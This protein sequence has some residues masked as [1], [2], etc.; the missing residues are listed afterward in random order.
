MNKLDEHVQIGFRA[1]KALVKRLDKLAGQMS[2]PGREVSRS[3]ALR[4][5]AFKGLEQLEAETSIIKQGKK[6]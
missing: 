6:R 2:E 4:L 5:A 3:E 1:P